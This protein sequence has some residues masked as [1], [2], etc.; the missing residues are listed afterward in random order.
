MNRLRLLLQFIQTKIFEF[1]LFETELTWDDPQRRRRE[2]LI[3]RIHFILLAITTCIMLVYTSLTIETQ[4]TIIQSPSQVTFDRLRMNNDYLPTLQCPCQ[5]ITIPYQS[6][7]SISF[8]LHQLCSSDFIDTT[9]S[10]TTLLYSAMLSQH[11]SYDDFRLFALLHF[12][13]LASLCQLANDTITD[14]AARFGMKKL[15]TDQINIQE[16]IE[17]KAQ[18]ALSQFR[19]STIRKFVR[20]LDLTRSV[21]QGNGIVSAIQS[22]WH[23]VAIDRINFDTVWTLP[24]SYGDQHTCSCMTSSLCTSS[25]S[26]NGSIIPG[27]RVGCYPLDSLL[28][29]TLECLYYK[30]CLETL[31]SIDTSMNVTITPLNATI[32]SPNVTVQ[33][34]VN[35]L[36]IDQWKTDVSY[37]NYYSHCAP[38]SCSYSLNQRASLLY[39]ITAIIGFYGGLSTA[40]KIIAPALTKIGYSLV[41]FYRTRGARRIALVSI[42]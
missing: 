19:I 4:T 34:L 24:R 31:T 21:S 25:A 6:F 36:L 40:L 14:A 2:I 30:N 27:F 23:F 22:N 18:A 7:T 38:L 3:T 33:S 5:N 28:Q 13:L 15:I 39:I 26:I 16:T 12:R 42:N 32:S 41:G 9:S 37:E 1:N 17:A 20:T 8:E 29:S 11:H 35:D 10:W